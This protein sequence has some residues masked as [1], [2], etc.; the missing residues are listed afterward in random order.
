MCAGDDVARINERRLRLII[1]QP[2]SSLLNFSL[3]SALSCP[4]LNAT[5]TT[6]QRGS[7]DDLDPNALRQDRSS[8]MFSGPRRPSVEAE[9]VEHQQ[10]QRASSAATNETGILSAIR[11]FTRTTR[12]GSTFEDSMAV[13]VSG[14]GGVGPNQVAARGRQGGRGSPPPPAVYGAP[15]GFPARE[16][17]GGGADAAAG[18]RRGR[19]TIFSAGPAGPRRSIRRSLGT[20]SS[21]GSSTSDMGGSGRNFVA[22]ETYCLSEPKVLALRYLI[23]HRYW[24]AATLV[25][26]LV[27]LFGP[28]VNDIW[29]PKSA[30]AGVDAALTVSFVVL[31]IDII[32]RCTVDR[33]YFAFDRRGTTWSYLDEKFCGWQRCINFRAG[34]FMFWF[35]T[36]RS[37]CNAVARILDVAVSQQSLY[38]RSPC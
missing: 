13:G 20:R 31:V 12:L 33:S 26:I 30:D 18:G 37:C 27:C 29:L 9:G 32:I 35:D 36:V 21:L 10:H 2:K 11:R 4:V 23:N 34:S 25:F 28:S 6:K 24:R 3:Q 15:P 14:A 17:S 16:Q 5:T 8:L 22:P 38:R 7:V 19:M 1:R